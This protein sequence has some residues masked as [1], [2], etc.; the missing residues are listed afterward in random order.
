[1]SISRLDQTSIVDQSHAEDGIFPSLLL[2]RFVSGNNQNEESQ[3]RLET[4]FW[5]KPK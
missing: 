1:M 5:E 4:G 2:E 3:L